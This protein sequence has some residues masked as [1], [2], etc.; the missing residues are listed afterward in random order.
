[1]TTFTDVRVDLI[2]Q[3]PALLAHLALLTPGPERA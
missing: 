1:V 3:A 2:R